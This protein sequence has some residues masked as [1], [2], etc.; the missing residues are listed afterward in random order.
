M[1][2][3][4]VEQPPPAEVLAEIRAV[5][6]RAKGGDAAAVPRLRELLDRFPALWKW[7]GDLAA[8]AERAWIHLAAGADLHLRESLVRFAADQ[9]AALTRPHAPPIERLLVDRAVTCWV[10]LQY[11]TATEAAA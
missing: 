6:A 2:R 9:R 10:E 8:Q 1:A 4:G 3:E 7:Y 11:F 5:V